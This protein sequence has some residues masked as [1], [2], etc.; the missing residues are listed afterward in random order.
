MFRI[1]RN[2]INLAAGRSIN[3][4]SE[5]EENNLGGEWQD[6]GTTPAPPYVDPAVQ[7]LVDEA[8][9]K[10]RQIVIAAKSEAEVL[11]K[12]TRVDIDE[13]YAQAMREG[14]EQGNKEAKQTADKQLEEDKT[15]LTRVL[16]EIYAEN[17]RLLESLEDD[18]VSLALGIVK[19]I[20]NP[21]DD[22]VS[23]LFNL[24]IQNALKQIKLTDKITI[25]VGPAEYERF[26]STG[27]AVF[28]LRGGVDAKATVL[29][30]TSMNEG[31][32]VI[33]T[34]LE[35]INAGLD[36]QLRLIQLAFENLE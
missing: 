3:L 33:D 28:N 13:A 1:D 17:N 7:A 4:D 14:W 30:N 2:L 16:D 31:D 27:S 24:Q 10:A 21:T 9:E 19:K 34:E 25:Q 5:P 8:E 15:A 35:T 20:Y 36:S 32:C 23:E 22:T 12:E 26:F 18:L 11:L 6:E 29:K